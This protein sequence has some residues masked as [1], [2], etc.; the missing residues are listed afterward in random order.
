MCRDM[1]LNYIPAGAHR[2][3]VATR[4]P[5]MITAPLLQVW[6]SLSNHPAC[7]IFNCICYI[8]FGLFR[9]YLI[10]KYNF[11]YAMITNQM[12]EAV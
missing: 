11:K 10:S 3:V 5:E 8:T 2:S 12:L 7:S 6:N 4:G 1:F 9:T